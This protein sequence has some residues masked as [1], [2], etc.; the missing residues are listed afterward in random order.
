LER[1]LAALS[2]DEREVLARASGLL[3]RLAAQHDNEDD[4]ADQPIRRAAVG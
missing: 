3:D 1:Q 2:E 4:A